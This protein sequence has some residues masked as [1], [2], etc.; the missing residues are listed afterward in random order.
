MA[1]GNP[2]GQH[3]P[4]WPWG[5]PRESPHVLNPIEL[6][7]DNELVLSTGK[8]VLDPSI[9]SYEAERHDVCVLMRQQQAVLDYREKRLNI[10]TEHA[11][12]Q[13]Q[14]RELDGNNF[15]AYDE[16]FL[17]E[18][19]FPTPTSWPRPN[20]S[21]LNPSTMIPP[22]DHDEEPQEPN[23]AEETCACEGPH[24]RAI[25]FQSREE[26]RLPQDAIEC[27]GVHVSDGLQASCLRQD[28]GVGADEDLQEEVPNPVQIMSD[29]FAHSTWKLVEE[30]IDVN[31]IQTYTLIWLSKD[32]FVRRVCLKIVSYW[33]FDNAILALILFGTTLMVID[34]PGL[35]KRQPTMKKIIS[36]CDELLLYLFSLEM[37]VKV[38]ASGFFR[39]AYDSWNQLDALVVLAGWISLIS[40]QVSECEHHGL[41]FCSEAEGR[42][43]SFGA[44]RTLR[45][46]RPLRAIKQLPGMQVQVRALLQSLPELF[47][48]MVLCGFILVLF[49]IIGVQLYMGLFLQRC[50]DDVTNEVSADLCPLNGTSGFKGSCDPGKT[51]KQ[52]PEASGPISFD[53]LGKAMLAVYQ[54]I[55]MEG[56]VDIMYSLRRVRGLTPDLYFISLI[57]F[58][59]LFMTNLFV[60]VLV[61]NF[62]AVTR[63]EA[64]KKEAHALRA[65]GS[66]ERSST[67]I[68]EIKKRLKKLPH[69][70]SMSDVVKGLDPD[71]YGWFRSRALKFIQTPCFGT[72]VMFL[73][74]LNTLVLALDNVVADSVL[75]MCNFIFT[76]VFFVEMIIKNIGYTTRGYCADYFNLFD[77]AIVLVSLIDILLSQG[78]GVSSAS[79]TV[80]RTFRLLRV[81]KL[82]RSMR[83]LRKILDALLSSVGPIIDLGWLLLL[84][85][86]VVALMGMSLYGVSED[87]PDAN[88]VW[89][90]E[91][92]GL[93]KGRMV[94]PN[95]SN[96]LYSM[97]TVFI[98]IT[99]EN[100]NEVMYDAVK[101][102]GWI[103]SLFFVIVMLIGNYIVLNLFL[104]V[105]IDNFDKAGNNE[106]SRF[107]MKSAAAS[108]ELRTR[109]SSLIGRLTLRT[110]TIS[111]PARQGGTKG[112]MRR[113]CS[114]RDRID[115]DGFHGSSLLV[116]S[117][118]NCVRLAVWKIIR[119]PYFDR[120]I[121]GL[122]AVSAVTLA[123][124][125]PS[126]DSA[127]AKEVFI[128][129]DI[130][131]T[132]IFVVEAALKILV[133]GFAFGPNTY[134]ADPWNLL[135][136]FVLCTSAL[137]IFVRLS[138]FGVVNQFAW[139]KSL[140][141]LRALRPLR[142]VSRNEG[143]KAV[144]DSM[145][146]AIPAIADVM[147]VLLLFLLIFSILGV[148]LM[149]GKFF[150]CSCED[151]CPE[152]RHAPRGNIHTN[153]SNATYICQGICQAAVA[154][155]APLSQ[156]QCTWERHRQWSFDNV[157]LAMLTLFEVSTL[158][159]WPDVVWLAVDGVDKH[160]G[161]EYNRSPYVVLFFIVFLFIMSFFI[162]NLFIGVVIDKFT[163]VQ[164]EMNG[165]AVLTPQQH[166]WIAAQR[167]LLKV[168]PRP[169]ILPPESKFRQLA[170]QLVSV[171]E[172]E[173]MVL[174][175]IIANAVVMCSNI[176]GAPT[177]IQ[178]IQ[179]H[180]NV[181]FLGFF[182]AET[183]LKMYAMHLRLY[184]RD[185]WNIFDLALVSGSLLSLTMTWAGYAAQVDPAMLRGFR[186]ARIFRLV[187]RLKSLRKLL[188]TL[189][190][191]LPSLVNITTLLLLVFFVY[192]VAGMALFGDI[193]IEGNEE[194]G[195][196][197]KDNNFINFYLAVIMLFRMST[198]E[199]WN[200][201]MHDCFSGAR[202]AAPPHKE[203]CGNT[204]I[205]VFFFLSFM[206]IC[207]FVFL[208]M[209]IAVIVD[210][211]FE[212]NQKDEGVEMTLSEA[213]VEDFV[214]AWARLVPSGDDYIPTGKVPVLLTN[215][216]PPLG[217]HGEVIA[218]RRI[219]RLLL[220]LGIR[221]HCGRVHFAEMLW[222]LAAMVVGTDMRE[223]ADFEVLRSL[224]KRV[225]RAMPVPRC[226]E[227]E[228]VL[229][230][231][232]QVWA[233]LKLQSRWRARQAKKRMLEA[234][235]A[236][237][238][239]LRNEHPQP[240]LETEEFGNF[241]LE[242][243]ANDALPTVGN[244]LPHNSDQESGIKVRG[245][246]EGAMGPTSDERS[247]SQ[248]SKGSSAEVPLEPRIPALS[249]VSGRI[250]KRVARCRS[251]A[252]IHPS[253]TLDPMLHLH[254]DEKGGSKSEVSLDNSDRSGKL[255][256][257]L[258]SC[259][260]CSAASER[261]DV[262]EDW[263]HCGEPRTR[264][265]QPLNV[266]EIV[267]LPENSQP[268]ETSLCSAP[269]LVTLENQDS[270]H[271]SM[272]TSNE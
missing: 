17:V 87:D 26:L 231:A 210:K 34:E 229:Y 12:D 25:S 270:L 215:V 213:D 166:R 104:A 51:C 73:I 257:I 184:F 113:E 46:L 232:A 151:W 96:F 171:R 217:F 122:I 91:E 79:V 264:C 134:L 152:R 148:Q 192:A 223:V 168:R 31:H 267:V 119:H 80:L 136:F 115:R 147:L 191:S 154:S 266:E 3:R 40:S 258:S 250:A 145:F 173:V 77:G 28:P 139:T 143:M 100:W 125:S 60:A 55:T 208:N 138:A 242:I 247:S 7:N 97:T 158:E 243:V 75:E 269:E 50:V 71:D 93:Y 193:Q 38:I 133:F 181:V 160:T 256:D 68:P 251:P 106:H 186:I 194:L 206:L 209:F 253:C 114:L 1:L 67:G 43:T 57:L 159:M 185:L 76:G 142:M 227:S 18:E 222:R 241:P 15:N 5:G 211:L 183:S 224:D 252:P 13:A 65:S 239:V 128:A 129:L 30:E 116:F 2:E 221:D 86:I 39:Y 132:C 246:D 95:F 225:I 19:E 101:K 110:T 140:R 218:G 74:I 149:K 105:L 14:S 64:T 56:W 102:N 41:I 8:R 176:Y 199:S 90:F 84:F 21:T 195:Q 178:K 146:K 155:S 135:D 62:M 58:G 162:L 187:K 244:S 180:A 23:P 164:N 59:S 196:M 98:T 204:P 103:H 48:T 44:L 220:R 144:V 10:K 249:P 22:G 207:S 172:F 234:V 226:L 201:I 42:S 27:A 126:V 198:G 69:G 120:F 179:E 37:M 203:S 200:G 29:N 240:K 130:V 11:A 99:G 177:G 52:V 268:A 197:S 85:M 121:Y 36:V 78:F 157:P 216:N 259:G 124:D 66:S 72:L 174:G 235:T 212:A 47:D 170:L 236:Q 6:L 117:P 261:R 88:K 189:V 175:M 262:C 89:P 127:E 254:M 238:N 263:S 137:N 111:E 9:T 230:L 265:I 16:S 245:T 190:T 272:F 49:G 271:P 169:L 228:E 45:I 153:T 188:E 165:K 156:Q 118:D 260:G 109:L 32:H 107:T 131:L 4:K 20:P 83:S 255:S 92:S 33:W 53:N 163:D 205:A 167:L 63:E 141:A 182:V 112:T 35:D 24:P 54:A 150:R 219:L 81:F 202:C 214:D 248:E 108:R 94:R 70:V 237:L 123:L 233:C 161:P 82:A 61:S